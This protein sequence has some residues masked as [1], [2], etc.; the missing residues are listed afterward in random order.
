MVRTCNEA[1]VTAAA[2]AIAGTDS[3]ASGDTAWRAMRDMAD[4]QFAPVQPDPP[5]VTPEWLKS[6]M[7]WLASLFRPLGKLLGVNWGLVETLLMIGVGLGAAW[8]AWSLMWPLWRDRKPAVAAPPAPS[9]AP[10]REQA[11]ALL[12]EADRLA[13]EGRYGEAA[14]L[15]LQRSIGHI[16]TARPEWLRPSST[17]REIGAIHDLPWGAK[18]AFAVIVREVER[19]VYAL[20]PLEAQDWGRARAAYAEFALADLRHSA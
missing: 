20:R 8:I 18:Q 17:A 16:R 13:A 5:P 15:L 19:A 7:E 6:L 11:L 9:W 3:A 4:I 1:G 14:H 10:L 12:E 2:G